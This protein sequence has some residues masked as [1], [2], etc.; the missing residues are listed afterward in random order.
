MKEDERLCDFVQHFKFQLNTVPD[1]S[2]I[3][4]IETFKTAVR[5]ERCVADI[6]KERLTTIAHLM[7]IVKTSAA[8][9][10][11]LHRQRELDRGSGQA[12]GTMTRKS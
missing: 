11:Q 8:I 1:V 3:N 9:E 7:D 5:N 12:G 6:I 4:V 10:Y 2:P